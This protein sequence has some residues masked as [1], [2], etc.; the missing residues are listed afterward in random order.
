MFVKL[1]WCCEV[2]GLSIGLCC[3]DL[4]YCE[5]GIMRCFHKYV[6]SLIQLDC[7]NGSVGI[8][9]Y[10]GSNESVNR[11]YRTGIRSV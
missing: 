9:G 10:D 2:M 7:M 5:A 3:E 4:Q 8:I 6:E 11:E 1:A